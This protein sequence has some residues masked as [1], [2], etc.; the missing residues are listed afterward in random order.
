MPVQTASSGSLGLNNGGDDLTLSDG[1]T[2]QA[3][4]SYGSEGGNNQSL[5]RDPDGT[6]S[7]FVLHTLASGSG[8]ALYSPGTRVDGVAFEGCQAPVLEIFQIQGPGLASPYAGSVV[9]T[10]DNV[11]TAVAPNGFTMQ[12]PDAR[13]DADPETSNGIFVFTG[14]APTVTVGDRV[15]VNGQVVEFF[16]LT[17]L[18]NSPTVTIVG[19]GAALPAAVVFDAATPS[20]NQPQPA[21]EIE[22]YEGMRVSVAD[23]VVGGPNQSFGTDPIAEVFVTASGQR[24]F[25]EPGIEYPG[26]AG[27]PL[28]DG[29]PE[30]FELDLDRLGLPS[31]LVNAG[32][33]FSAEGVIGYEFGDYELWPTSYDISD[34][35]LPRPVRERDALEYTVGG[36]NHFRLFDDVDDPGSEDNGQVV[37]SAE[38]ATRLAKFSQ[39]IRTVLRAPDVLAVSEVESLSVLADLADKIAAD[40]PA[41]QYTPYLVEGNDVGGIDVGF[42]VGDRVTVDAVTQLAAA[43][44]LTFDGSL[45]HDRPPLL[46]EGRVSVDGVDNPI[47]VLAVHMRSLGGI[48]D[49][50][51]GPRVRQK[52]L[53]QA[54]SVATIVADRLAL[55]PDVRLVVIGD[56]NA[57]QFTDGYVD[58]VGQIAG[59][60]VPADNLLSGPDLVDPDLTVQ[61][62]L[63]PAAER[64]SFVFR[65]SAQAI[66]HA[67]TSVGADGLVRGYEYGRGNA[68]APFIL[69]DDASTPLRSSDH[70]GVVLFLVS[71]RDGDGVGDD[72]DNC[73]TTP[74]PDQADADGDGFGDACDVCPVGTVIPEGAPTVA[75]LPNHYALVDG[76]QVFDTSP[77]GKGPVETFTLEDTGGC[78][79]EQIVDVLGLGGGHLMHG[80]NVGL[81][82]RWVSS[83][84]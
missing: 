83:V 24:A 80:C 35:A 36:L 77:R 84:P 71:D 10:L 46:L 44:T 20:P 56:F 41:V 6:A 31:E 55:D 47:E 53:E 33:T 54:Q 32:S 76:D 39:Y 73:L 5:T 61:T 60:A 65:G 59:D 3:A 48:D 18:T 30:V 63:A 49:P 25:R 42:L 29:N 2:V 70:D 8:G 21:T 78:S 75:L 19:S 40:D 67:L 27:L 23:G 12:T 81:M 37:S 43:E 26:I 45:L 72:V 82:R 64:Y 51:D 68:D 58:V 14:A 62:R 22:R 50:S 15:D 16:D 17:E 1:G 38:Y 11:V 79:C 13:A 7:A 9:T 28:W 74:N 69:L 66:D 34:A 4:A 52:R 57:Y